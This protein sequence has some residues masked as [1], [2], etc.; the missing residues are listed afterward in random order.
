M[1]DGLA[2]R[3]SDSLVQAWLAEYES[4]IVSN[5]VPNMM[6]EVISLNSLSYDASAEFRELV[7]RASANRVAFYPISSGGRGSGFVSAEYQGTGS[8][9]DL[10]SFAVEGASREDALLRM[11]AGTGDLA[12]TRTTNVDRLLD[13]LRRDFEAFYSLGYNSPLAVDREFHKIEVKVRGEGLKV[14]HLQ[15]YREKDPLDRL[16]DLTLS[17]LH[18]AIEDN[19]LG[20]RLAP[21]EQ[22]ETGRDRYQVPVTIQ[23]PFRKLLLVPE[24]QYHTGTVSVCVVARDER[25]GVSRPQR[26]DLSIR[27]PNDQI[28]QALNAGA[29]YPMQLEMR[30]GPQRLAVG[31]RDQLGRVDSTINVDLVVGPSD[32]GLR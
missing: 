5:D 21:G 7:E 29:A 10:A 11:A 31:V 28:L 27:I 25:G 9:S 26:L 1:S 2:V 22:V 17:A 24:G 8:G 15:G 14:R 6:S 32:G 18:Y 13:R 3:A 20:V 30:R 16:Q 19:P 4:W 23:I 12:F